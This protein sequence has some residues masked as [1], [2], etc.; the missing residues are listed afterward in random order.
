[1]RREVLEETGLDPQEPRLVA[2]INA[3]EAGKPGVVL[4]V[5]LARATS[6]QVRESAEGTL[7]WIPRGSLH[8]LHLV[9]D[10]SELLPR[11]LNAETT[12]ILYGYYGYDENGK[13]SAVQW[14]AR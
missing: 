7:H 5:F 4:F 1:V 8:Q 9:P 11:I 2:V 14:N 10:L 6:Q 13:L 12:D 3:D